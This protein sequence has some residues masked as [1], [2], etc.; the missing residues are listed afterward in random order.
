MKIINALSQLVREYMTLAKAGVLALWTRFAAWAVKLLTP[1]LDVPVVA[2]IAHHVEV[3][4]ESFAIERERSLTA[5]KMA[6]T[7]FLPAALEVMETPPNPVG[8]AILWIMIGFLVIAGLWAGFGKVDEVAIAP[9]KLI[10][11]GEVKLIQAPDYGIVRAIHIVDG[12][13]VKKGEPL[14]ELDPTVSGAEAEQARKSLLVARTDQVRARALAEHGGPDEAGTFAPPEGVDPESAQTQKAL[15]EEKI[16]EHD[17][18]HAAL[19]QE[20]AQ[21]KSE[22][23]MVEAEVEKLKA[24]LPLAEYQYEAIR[25]LADE[26]YAPKLRVMEL[27]ERVIGLRQDLAIRRAEATKVRAVIRGGEQQ[28]AKLDSEFKRQALDALNEAE[29]AVSLRGEELKKAEEKSK[30]TVLK[31]PEDGIVQQLAVHTL[32]AV[33]KPAD[34][35][36]VV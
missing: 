23:A 3:A 7:A 19:M 27:Q 29:A 18:A 28:L 26:G 36:L 35:L 22:L 25:G 15:V 21:H 8:R 16:R 1:L 14:I 30:L 20:I 9:G 5:K 24:Q 2:G 12:Q 4:K 31:A 11:R 13:L 10:P 17:A 33:V 32:G 34:A 6:E